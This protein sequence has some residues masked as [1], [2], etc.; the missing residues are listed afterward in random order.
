MLCY[1]HVAQQ[2]FSVH[3]YI[4]CFAVLRLFFCWKIRTKT[5]HPAPSPGSVFTQWIHFELLTVKKTNCLLKD[6]LQNFKSTAI[7]KWLDELSMRHSGRNGHK[8]SDNV[9][10]IHS[11]KELPAKSFIQQP[12]Q[13]LQTDLMPR[14]QTKKATSSLDKW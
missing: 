3:I 5:I 1:S 12:S 11:T 13:S 9:I 6:D 10:V 4:N 2:S 8:N 7:I 14:N